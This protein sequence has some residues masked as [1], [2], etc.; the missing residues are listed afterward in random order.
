MSA[1]CCCTS[2]CHKRSS[3]PRSAHRGIAPLHGRR[4]LPWPAAVLATP[5]TTV[6]AS[7]SSGEAQ[8]HAREGRGG[9]QGAAWLAPWLL[10]PRPW[11]EG[12][13]EGLA[14]CQWVAAGPHPSPPQRGEGGPSPSPSPAGGRG[15]KPG[16]EWLQCACATSP[17]RSM[18]A[19]CCC[20][21]PCHKPLIHAPICST[22]ASRR[23]TAGDSCLCPLLLATPITT[24]IASASSGEA[25]VHAR[26][27][28]AGLKAQ[29]GL[30]LG[31]CSLAPLG[32][33]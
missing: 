7:A 2:P 4:Q 17:P 23:S 21:S 8:V 11:G 14:A 9:A 26:G 12:R 19:R 13:G 1:R 15:S 27:G 6:I 3:T 20:T 24:V 30:L 29:H 5:I 22:V 31:C 18:S 33:G 16:G 32:R 25:Q 28:G 10:L